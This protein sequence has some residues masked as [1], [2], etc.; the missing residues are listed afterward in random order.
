MQR[1]SIEV[2][3]RLMIGAAAAA[4]GFDDNI[5]LKPTDFDIDDDSG[6]IVDFDHHQKLLR[7]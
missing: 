5:D 2:N 4:L 3:H 1:D 7:H 6:G